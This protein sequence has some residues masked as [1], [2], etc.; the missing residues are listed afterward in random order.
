MAELT[1]L[2][3]GFQAIIRNFIET[4]RAPH[5]TELAAALGLPM[6]EGRQ[7]L[8]D[9]VDTGYPM[10]FVPDTDYILSVAPFSNLPNHCR[11]SVEGE[12]KW[13]AQ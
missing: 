2:D 13:F 5:Y 10:G 8:H 11:I 1:L 3:R 4:G 7:L 9:L 6:E 12:Q